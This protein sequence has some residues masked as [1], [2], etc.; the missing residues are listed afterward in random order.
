MKK[1]LL[2]A[3]LLALPF[4]AAWPRAGGGG[5]GGGGCFPAG[6][7]VDT[8]AGGIPIENL[9]ADDRVLAYGNDRIV[10]AAVKN[11]YKKEDRL[12]VIRTAK[13]KL[14]TT[15][16]HPLLTRDGFTEARDL[17]K[18]MEV[19]VMEEGRR[20]WR[21][22]RSIKTGGISTVYNLEVAPPHTFIADG[23]IV[24]NKGG[25]GYSG[26]GYYHSSGYYGSDG[27]Y[28]SGSSPTENYFIFALIAVVLLIKGISFFSERQSSYAPKKNYLADGAAVAP[29][30]ETTLAIMTSLARTDAA[31]N[32]GELESFVRNVFMRVEL[33]WQARDYSTVGDVMLPSILAEHS[34]QVETMRQRHEVNMMD[35]LKVLKIDFVH[36]RCPVEKE[37]RSFTVLITASACDYTIDENSNPAGSSG[38]AAATFQEYWTFYQCNGNWALARIDQV[39]DLDILGAP[40][41]PDR[42]ENA[43]AF[44]GPG[45]ASAGYSTETAAGIMSAAADAA[46]AVTAAAVVMPDAAYAPPPPAP[47]QD[48]TWNR[49]KMEIAATLAFESVYEA[50]GENDSSRLNAECVSAETLAKLKRIMEARKA[51][52]LL[53]EFKDLFARRAEVVLT[54]PAQESKLG[55]DEFTARITATAVRTLLHNGRPL[56]HDDA[57]QPFTEYWVFVRQAD[58]WKLRDILPR[59]DQK[60]TGSAQD[61]EPSPVQIEWYWGT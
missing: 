57:P 13:G 7:I 4:A 15:A 18:G 48:D 56:H 34:A 5:G 47:Q 26:G 27:L 12:L 39:G 28:H 8:T 58:A 20:V 53:F 61:G 51:E 30:A 24:H 59:M 36:V 1:R 2:F 9:R 25:G 21:K 23:F 17:K 41:L 60:E 46:G 43:Q 45:A 49:Q 32:P 38:A 16:E 14:T 31:F 33:A 37:G 42:P 6:T 44:A 10:Q 54:S 22:I 50:W 35:D 52:G 40:N 3:L 55:L 19:G 11:V 29:R